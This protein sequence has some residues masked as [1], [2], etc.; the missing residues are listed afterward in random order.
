MASSNRSE[1]EVQIIVIAFKRRVGLVKHWLK[2]AYITNF[3]LICL[4]KDNFSYT[5]RRQL[6]KLGRPSQLYSL[7]YCG[8][9]NEQ[10]LA[11]T[12]HLWLGSFRFAVIAIQFLLSYVSS[13]YSGHT[14]NKKSCVL[15][16]CVI[17]FHLF[18]SYIQQLFPTTTG[19]SLLVNCFLNLIPRFHQSWNNFLS[20][21]FA[22]WPPRLL[23][24]PSK[25]SQEWKS[26]LD[27]MCF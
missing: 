18:Y 16:A 22:L 27:V 4:G 15:A 21:S 11:T 26:Q 10:K 7:R 6:A 23:Y 8:N 24:K 13:Q 1:Q 19:L 12:L 5:R 9:Y 3:V 25:C 2:N 20:S 14:T 17:L